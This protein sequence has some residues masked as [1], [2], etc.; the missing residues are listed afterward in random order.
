MPQ[1][2]VT[3]VN[4]QETVYVVNDDDT[5]EQRAVTTGLVNDDRVEILSGLTADQ[6]VVIAGQASLQDGAKVEVRN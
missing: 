6:Q 5:V 1:A 3:E 4:G 2:A